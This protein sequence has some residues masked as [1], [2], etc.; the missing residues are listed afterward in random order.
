MK[1]ITSFAGAILILSLFISILIT[2]SCTQPKPFAAKGTV[3]SIENGRDGYT[4]L[5]KGE[6]GNYF[7]AVI[8]RV[9]LQDQYK[10]LNAG[11]KV[12]FSGDTIHLDNKVRVL[13]TK[14]NP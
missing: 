6:D 12:S 11:D 8:S 13:V 1:K 14:I 5:V 2:S 9:K 4:A 3:E 7:D 10:V